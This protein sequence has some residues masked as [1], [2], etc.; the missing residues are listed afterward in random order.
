M[1]TDL[2]SVDL[3]NRTDDMLDITVYIKKGLDVIKKSTA[4][5]NHIVFLMEHGTYKVFVL[6]KRNKLIWAT[7]DIVVSIPEQLQI[8]IDLAKATIDDSTVDPY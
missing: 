4:E 6:F 8:D 5:T 7:D 3:K 1:K 2:F